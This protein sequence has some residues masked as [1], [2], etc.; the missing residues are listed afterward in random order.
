[1]VQGSN[2]EILNCKVEILQ[3]SCNMNK[4]HQLTV[5]HTNKRSMLSMNDKPLPL[6]CCCSV[7][8]L[9]FFPTSH[10]RQLCFYSDSLVRVHPEMQHQATVHWFRQLKSSA[11]EATKSLTWGCDGGKKV[12]GEHA[13]AKS[14]FPFLFREPDLRLNRWMIPLFHITPNSSQVFLWDLFSIYPRGA[15]PMLLC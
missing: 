2:A 4:V 12:R 5:A 9:F 13:A 3:L 1:M 10:V 11:G 7:L 14:L 15:S 6:N 8:L